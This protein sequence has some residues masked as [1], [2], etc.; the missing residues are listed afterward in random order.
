MVVITER[1]CKLT[2]VV[3]TMKT[4]ATRTSNIFME[5]WKAKFKIPS[6]VLTGISPQVTSNFFIAVCKELGVKMVATV[7]YHSQASGQVDRFSVTMIS[8]LRYYAAGHQKNWDTALSLQRTITAYKFTKLQSELRSA[9]RLNDYH[10]N[11][12]L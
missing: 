9:C 6:T 2:K 12:F 3:T 8:R 11:L 7:Y 5:H 1:Y 10:L 4:T